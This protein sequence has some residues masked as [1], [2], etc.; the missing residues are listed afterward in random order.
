MSLARVFLALGANLGDRILNLTHA[1]T[2]LPPAVRVL[3]CSAVYETPPWGYT[4]QPAFLNMV[5]EAETA[6][7]PLNL[8]KRLKF[9]EEKMGRQESVRFGPRLIDLDIL[10]YADQ[11]YQ[12]ER[13]EIPHPRLAERA[14]VL[15]PLADLAPDLMHPVTQQT[16]QELLS[17][18]DRGGITPITSPDHHPAAQIAE[19]LQSDSTV[20]DKYQQ[21]PPSHQREWLKYV[22]EPRKP[23]TRLRRLEKMAAQ[24]SGEG[25]ES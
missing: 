20:L 10:F 18:I 7:E 25:N 2:L 1:L 23:A 6:L 17:Q 9:L 5:C 13:L 11:V 21:M 15:V 8:L 19:F 12:D 16:I 4:D 24:I 22:L 14:F 3:R